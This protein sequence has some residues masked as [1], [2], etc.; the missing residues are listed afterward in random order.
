MTRSTPV[1]DAVCD[2]ADGVE[3][4][5]LDELVLRGL[6]I[7]EGLVARLKQLRVLARDG[8]VRADRR[9]HGQALL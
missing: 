8:D 4:L 3:L 2:E 1:R 7:F 5:G 9:Q 6:Q